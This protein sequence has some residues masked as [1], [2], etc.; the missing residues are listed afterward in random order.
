MMYEFNRWLKKNIYKFSN[1]PYL[2]KATTKNAEYKFKG[3]STKIRLY[4]DSGGQFMIISKT[5]NNWDDILY[6]FD[7]LIKKT[8]TGKY[9]CGFCSSKYRRYY[10]SKTA[11]HTSQC[12]KPFIIWV[13]E[14]LTTGK[15]LLILGT[16]GWSDGRI[17]DTRIANKK[18]KHVKFRGP[19]LVKNNTKTKPNNGKKKRLLSI[20]H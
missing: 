6:E 17:M 5:R 8:R 3:V 18:K 9:F 12:F 20:R 1:T 14:N 19:V 15:S 10:N 2:Y 4:M 16:R 13:S 7:V 11:L